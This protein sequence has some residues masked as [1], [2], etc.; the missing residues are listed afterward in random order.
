MA[1]LVSDLIIPSPVFDKVRDLS[2]WLDPIRPDMKVDSSRLSS[3]LDAEVDFVRDMCSRAGQR[4]A[5]GMNEADWNENVNRPLLRHAFEHPGNASSLRPYNVTSV[6][7]LPKLIDASEGLP[8]KIV[9]YVLASAHFA[10]NTSPH[11]KSALAR[12]ASSARGSSE[13]INHFA[14]QPTWNK[15]AAVSIEVKTVD[16]SESE[17]NIQVAVWAAAQFTRLRQLTG[18]PSDEPVG[19]TLPLIVVYGSTWNLLLAVDMADQIVSF[20]SQR[21][22]LHSLVGILSSRLPTGH[23]VRAIS[24]FHYTTHT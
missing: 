11:V 3:D 1:K 2:G 9:D 7:L 13:T 20:P 16:N 10:D 6:K 15:P 23:A 17:A 5:E 22:F 8:N 21:P 4:L 14:Y 12:Q 18:Q 24:L 19:L